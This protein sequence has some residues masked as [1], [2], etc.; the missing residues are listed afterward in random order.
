MTAPQHDTAP[1]ALQQQLLMV[2][3]H[4]AGGGNSRERQIDIARRRVTR[5]ASVLGTV[6]AAVAMYDLILLATLGR[7]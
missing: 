2:Q 7:G 4:L 5:I 3:L 1:T 6:A